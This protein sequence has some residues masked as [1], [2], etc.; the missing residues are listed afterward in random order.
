MRTIGV[1][2]GY[3]SR[4]ELEKGMF[5]ICRKYWKKEDPIMAEKKKKST[6]ELLEQARKAKQKPRTK[7]MEKTLGKGKNNARFNKVNFSG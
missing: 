7:A 4:M 2:Y 5:S 1:L 6:A 3:G